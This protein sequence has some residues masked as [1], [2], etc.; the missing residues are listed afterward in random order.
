L[1]FNDYNHLTG[2]IQKYDAATGNVINILDFKAEG[3]ESRNMNG[4]TMICDLLGD[5]REEILYET[6][7][8]KELRIYTTT[9]PS[10]N[11]IYTLMH[12]PGY[13]VQT[14]CLGRIGGFFVDYY[15]GPQMDA[16]PPSSF[17]GED[18]R[19]SGANAIWDVNSTQA[20]HKNFIP[21]TF[22]QGNNVL[23]DEQLI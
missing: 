6:A 4:V 8:T 11:R 23:F 13:R 19:W 12:N 17:A 18:I 22:Q 2:N 3:C 16:V 14:T 7:D 21:M 10:K 15:F 1:V 5:W 20:W 9:I